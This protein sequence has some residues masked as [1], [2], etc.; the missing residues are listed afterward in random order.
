MN[1]KFQKYP[2]N[3][4]GAAFLL[5]LTGETASAFTINPPLGNH[6]QRAN[7]TD[8]SVRVEGANLKVSGYTELQ[9]IAPSSLYAPL[10]PPSQDS[11]FIKVLEF[12]FPSTNIPG[13]PWT[14]YTL[15]D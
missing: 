5:I 8:Y 2:G 3:F 11:T 4:L 12:F 10:P 9:S 15:Y 7:Y 1:L 6:F 14:G 13:R